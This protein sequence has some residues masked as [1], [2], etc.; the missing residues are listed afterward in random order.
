MDGRQLASRTL[1]AL[2]MVAMTSAWV[3]PTS[4]GSTST[5]GRDTIRPDAAPTPVLVPT[6]R[7]AAPTVAP[8]PPPP[9]ATQQVQIGAHVRTVMRAPDRSFTIVTEQRWTKRD[10]NRRALHATIGAP[11]PSAWGLFKTLDAR[12]GDADGGITTCTNPADYWEICRLVH[13]RSL[14]ELSAVF[15]TR[16]M[17]QRHE[18]VLDGEPAV[19]LE[20][21]AAERP[22]KGDQSLVYILAMHAGRPYAIRLW[23]SRGL[24]TAGADDVIAGFRFRSPHRL[25]SIARRPAD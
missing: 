17:G 11:S 24:G 6:T 19:M 23:S 7:S 14:D 21:H 25:G 5:V 20:Y 3:T 8:E 9:G 18:V 10:A 12:R 2:A 4:S 1:S 13:A 15:D 22:A 16:L